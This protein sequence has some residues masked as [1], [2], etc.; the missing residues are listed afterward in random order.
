MADRA[1]SASFMLNEIADNVM[2]KR[3]L[4]F[5]LKSFL[6]IA[7]MLMG[8][9]AFAQGQFTVNLKLVDEKTS[10]PVPFATASLTVKGEAK[11]AKYVLTDDKGQASLTKV[12][13]GTYI[14]KAELMGYKAFQQEIVVDKNIDLGDVKMAEDVEVLDAAN[15]SAAG[16]PIIV[17]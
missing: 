15:V 4:G 7:L 1:G 16:N 2:Q 8:F 11:A 12:K 6:S 3:I 9:S 10:E 5:F 14:V 17:K 13:K